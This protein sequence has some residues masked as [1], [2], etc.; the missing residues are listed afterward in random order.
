MYLLGSLL[1][2]LDAGLEA[3]AEVGRRDG[4]RLTAAEKERTR[5]IK[6]TQKQ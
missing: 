5:A 4:G 6:Q 3:V 2:I 1:E